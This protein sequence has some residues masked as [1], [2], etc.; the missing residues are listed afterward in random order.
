MNHYQEQL[1][2]YKDIAFHYLKYGR[3]YKKRHHEVVASA[4]IP[5]II[6]YC[7]FGRGEMSDFVKKCIA[8]WERKMPDYKLVLW[9]EDNFPMEEYPFAQ[10]ALADK[11]W[12]FV[13]DVAR[14]HALYTQGGIY[15]DTDV[16]VL[17][18]FDDLLKN[19]FFFGFESRTHIQ[20]AVMGSKMYHPF[21]GL[22]LDWYK[23]RNYDDFYYQT[24]N[25]RIVT[26]IARLY[27]G[28]KK[29]NQLTIFDDCVLYPRD[30]FCPT[31]RTRG[32]EITENTYCI[33][34][35]TRAW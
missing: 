4:E 11:K 21:T 35:F 14:L 3:A 23:N 18:S 2:F 15:F 9:N 32:Y 24:A 22:L 19:G 31:K 29:N 13:S 7:W 6:H 12:A 27:G 1:C 30:F 26:R 33:H 28:V 10:K 25:T 17:K 5:K 20:T 34:H 8:S 16:E